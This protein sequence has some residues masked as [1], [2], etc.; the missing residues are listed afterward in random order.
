MSGHERVVWSEGL[1]IGPAH[2]QQLD[3]YHERLLAARVDGVERYAW[4]ALSIELD[5]RALAGGQVQLTRFHGVLPD[6]TVLSLEPGDAAL[7]ASRPIDKH[8]PP[9]HSALEVFLA[10]PRER[11]GQNN[12]AETAANPARFRARPRKVYDV[13]AH[14]QQAEIAFCE[15]SLSLRYGD[16]PRED[17]VAIK[18]AEIV[19]DDSGGLVVCDPYIA[20]CLRISAS[21]FLMAALRRLLANMITRQKSLSEARRQSGDGSIEFNA[22]DVTRYLLLSTINGFIPVLAHLAEAGDA[23]P[24]QTYLLLC[25]LAGQLTTFDAK[26]DP[27]ALP[28]FLFLDLRATFE[29][30][31]GRIT[32]LLLSSVAEHFVAIPLQGRDDGMHT[33][34]LEDPRVPQCDR[35]FIAVKTDLPEQQVAARLPQL[36]KIA[37]FRD[38]H[39]ILSAATPGAPLEVSYRP[40]PEIPVKAGHVYFAVKTDNAYWRNVRTEAT[41]AVYLPPFFEP[42]RTVVELM[43]VPRRSGTAAPSVPTP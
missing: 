16:E 3:R 27:S 23:S 38:I 4:G 5:A 28:R 20:P 14:G 37:S 24:R 41:V 42:S 34:T 30:L 32:A 10:L 19:R 29:E 7:P 9:T 36:S 8:F 6:G 39:N 12:L 11:A 25:Q 43:G 40:P 17:F 31:F 2:L 18:V 22:A 33:G 1:L 26:A 35:F 21:P 13:A 15:P